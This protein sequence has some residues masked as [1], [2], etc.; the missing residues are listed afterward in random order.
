LNAKKPHR[1]A[2]AGL[3]GFVVSDAAEQHQHEDKADRDAE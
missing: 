1:L 3:F 2:P